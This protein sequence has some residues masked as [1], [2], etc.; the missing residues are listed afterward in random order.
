MPRQK[1]PSMVAC[2]FWAPVFACPVL[3]S[4]TV[5]AVR[6]AVDSVEGLTKLVEFHLGEVE[7]VLAVSEVSKVSALLIDLMLRHWVCS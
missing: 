3:I 2:P 6:D 1:E 5:V 4:T 7:Q